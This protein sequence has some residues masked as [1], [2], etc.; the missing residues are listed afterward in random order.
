MSNHGPRALLRQ[1]A[2]ALDD[3]RRLE[4]VDGIPR[5]EVLVEERLRRAAVKREEATVLTGLA[6]AQLALETAIANGVVE[7]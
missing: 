6:Q 1:A 5:S 3:A 2:V 4:D 7:P